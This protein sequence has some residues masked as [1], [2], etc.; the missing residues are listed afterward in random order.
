VKYNLGLE[1]RSLDHRPN[2]CQVL[3]LTPIYQIKRHG[4]GQRKEIDNRAWWPGRLSC[5]RAPGKLHYDLP[6]TLKGKKEGKGELSRMRTLGGL[7][8]IS[9]PHSLKGTANQNVVETAT[10][11][12]LFCTAN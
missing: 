8:R 7:L 12:L 2:A 6:V 3:P 4:E 9:S 5:R 1:A 11:M 10:R